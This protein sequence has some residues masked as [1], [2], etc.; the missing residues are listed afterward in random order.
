MEKDILL[1]IMYNTFRCIRA[2]HEI[3]YLYRDVKP[4][5]FMV[6]RSQLEEGRGRIYL[7]DLGL[8]KKFT[9]KDTSEHIALKVNKRMIGTPIFCSLNTHRGV[10]SSRRDDLESWVY[11]IVYLVKKL[12]WET[13][14]AQSLPSQSTETSPEIK[15]TSSDKIGK[16]KATTDFLQLIREEPKLPKCLLKIFEQIRHL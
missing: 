6:K 13:H 12:P 8:C 1:L 7:I 9:K 3:G 2:L 14:S 4:S 10:E 11:M 16:L 15:E 5:N